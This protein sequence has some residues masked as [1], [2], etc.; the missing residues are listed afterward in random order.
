MP[1]FL[2]HI[3]GSA[4]PSDLM[5]NSLFGGLRNGLPNA[6]ITTY[7][8]KPMVGMT[9]ATDPRG[10]TTYYEYDDFNRLKQTYIIENGEKK[11]LQKYDYHY[12]NQ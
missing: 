7:T 2:S 3:E 12:T 1:G 4:N 11:I 8:Y 5:L 9:S 6:L 10:V